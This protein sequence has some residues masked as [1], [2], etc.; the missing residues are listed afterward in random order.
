[1]KW[2]NPEVVELNIEET[3]SGTIDLVQEGQ[4]Y[5]YTDPNGVQHSLSTTDPHATGNRES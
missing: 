1:M 4:P 2:N 3:A 5:V